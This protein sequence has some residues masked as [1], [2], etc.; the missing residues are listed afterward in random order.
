M[1]EDRLGLIVA[2]RG[3]LLVGG[4]SVVEVSGESG[5]WSG[6]IGGCVEGCC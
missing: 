3:V 1:R 5:G 2:G 4:E 6:L